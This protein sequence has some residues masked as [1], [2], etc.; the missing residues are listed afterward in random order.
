LNHGPVAFLSRQK[1]PRAVLVIIAGLTAGDFVGPRAAHCEIKPRPCDIYAARNT[2]CVAA[3]STV[4]SLYTRYK[5]ALY[6]VK[7]ASDHAVRNIGL[8]SDGY[9]NAAAQDAFCA[10]TACIITKIY[11]QS[12]RHNDLTIAA[13]G[14]YKGP[15][16]K[17]SDLGAAAD[18]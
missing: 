15:G 4:R 1:A 18:A 13:G 17:G 2:P 16:L 12:P 9:A 8:L 3:H 10:N 7:R 14:H 5:G 11:D 6:Q